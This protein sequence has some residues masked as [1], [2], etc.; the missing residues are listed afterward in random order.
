MTRDT[1]VELRFLR[2]HIPRWA[3]KGL[4]IFSSSID[5]QV[6]TDAGDFGYGGHSEGHRFAGVL[7]PNIIGESSTYTKRELYA[8][9]KIALKLLH[10]LKHKKVRFIMDSKSAVRNLYNQGTITHLCQDYKHWME[11][12]NL[13]SIEPYYKWVPREENV[14]ADRLSKLIS[15]KWELR[16][17]CKRRILE[18][19]PRHT[20]H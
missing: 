13:H 17:A 19:F 1:W 4:P 5:V 15:L 2:A 8:M 14:K 10:I 20:P 9:R 16:Q 7:P 3:N 18:S 12:C 6:W 11:F